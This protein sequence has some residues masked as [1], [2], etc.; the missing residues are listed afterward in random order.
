MERPERQVFGDFELDLG[1][2][3]LLKGGVPVPVEPKALAV[4]RL[5]IERAP[6]AVEKGE[7]FATVWKDVSVTDNALT[8]I[9]AQLRRALDD[10]TKAPKYIETIATRGYRFVA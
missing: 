9:I 2:F 5:L 10:D 3:R 8:R 7:I 1:A 4:L 6:H